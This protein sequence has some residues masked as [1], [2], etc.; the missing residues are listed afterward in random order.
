M[1]E[2]FP[3]SPV[4]R[5]VTDRFRI[6]R[7]RSLRVRAFRYRSDRRHWKIPLGGFLT[8]PAVSRTEE[9]A[10]PTSFSEPRRLLLWLASVLR[11]TRWGDDPCVPCA[12]KLAL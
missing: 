1:G 8:K 12:V 9:L 2:E 4:V 5:D 7:R 6:N 11:A 10:K 3:P